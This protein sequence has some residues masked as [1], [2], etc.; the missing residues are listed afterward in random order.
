MLTVALQRQQNL[1]MAQ[2]LLVQDLIDGLT[3]RYYLTFKKDLC[4]LT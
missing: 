3:M 2:G 4:V 1:E